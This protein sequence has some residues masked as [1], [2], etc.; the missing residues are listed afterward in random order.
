MSRNAQLI[1]IALLGWVLPSVAADAPSAPA[2][3]PAPRVVVVQGRGLL[4][5]FLPDD[6]RVAAAFNQGL[7]H[8]TG[9][10]NPAAAWLTLVSTNDVVGLKVFS[11]PG[12]LCGTRPAVVRAIARGLLAAG[13]PRR[14][15][16]IWDKRAEDLRAAGYYDLGEELG[17]PVTGAVQ[18]GFDTN[19]FY[20][21]DSPVIGSLVWGDLEFGQTNRDTGKK[22]FVS[23]LV[24]RRLTKIISIA[25]L[26]DEYS[27]GVCGH[28]YSLAL[29]SVDNT[30]R[31]DNDPGRLAVALPEIVALPAVGDHTVLYVTDA[32]L[33]QYQGGPAA[34]LQFSTVLN[35][36][37]LSHDPVALDVLGQQ[38]LA[39]ERRRFHAPEM[40]PNLETYTNAALLQLGQNQPERIPI[41]TIR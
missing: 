5:A 39:R 12:Q 25:P 23:R 8:L 41:E 9:T 19:T 3:P 24:S 7:E 37:W 31:F 17:V 20:L 11:P 30:R 22:S 40:H 26:L 1:I 34:F 16:V 13:V 35:Q 21:P 4:N 28:F 33:A 27:A 36:L 10:T 15:I 6:D 14:Q 29:G 38:E 18:S 32:L 2:G